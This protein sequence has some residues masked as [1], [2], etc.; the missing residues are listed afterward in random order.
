MSTEPRISEVKTNAIVVNN[1]TSD[2]QQSPAVA[3][4]ID[5]MD[6]AACRKLCREE[7]VIAIK[8]NSGKAVVAN[9]V[10]AL[11]DRIDGK[12]PQAS[13]LTINANVETT[14]VLGLNESQQIEMLREMAERLER[15]SL[16]HIVIDN[17]SNQ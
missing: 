16:K 3:V 15:K 8:A 11:L 1:N 9:L 14:M 6:D 5:Y 12:A 7:L 4:D 10:N 13:E 2:Q 17:N